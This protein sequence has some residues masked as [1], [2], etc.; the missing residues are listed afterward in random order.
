MRS[1]LRTVRIPVWTI[2][3]LLGL[4]LHSVNS[5]VLRPAYGHGTGL[6]PYL[7]GVLPN[8][9]AA[10]V[11]F[12]FA[13]LM[14]VDSTLSKKSINAAL[15]NQYFWTGLMG[16][17]IGLIVWEYMQLEGNLVFDYNDIGATLLGGLCSIIIFYR[18]REAY[19]KT[20]N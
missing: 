10:G 20:K 4:A 9:L 14:I 16:S 15:V 1:L 11:I 8:F 19:L 2:L 5:D 7:L 6:F 3:T 17:Q 13:V 18:S 12:P